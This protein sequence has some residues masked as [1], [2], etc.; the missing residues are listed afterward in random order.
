MNKNQFE[1]AALEIGADPALIAFT[2]ELMDPKGATA[3]KAAAKH[4][5][6]TETATAQSAARQLT[7]NVVRFLA[8]DVK[9]VARNH[10]EKDVI[11]SEKAYKAIRLAAREE[12]GLKVRGSIPE[13]KMKVYL[14]AVDRLTAEAAAKAAAP[15]E[16]NEAE[17]EG[18]GA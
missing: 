18:V 1:T 17:S 4:M 8:Y 11:S 5:P 6:A 9:P 12:L 14:A 13:D 2:M 3:E 10:R 15:A 7:F 16:T